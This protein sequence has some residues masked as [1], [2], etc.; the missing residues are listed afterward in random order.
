M[1]GRVLHDVLDF[2]DFYK[3]N[4]VLVFSGQVFIIQLKNM[5]GVF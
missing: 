2:A 5:F 4:V 1:I 3:V